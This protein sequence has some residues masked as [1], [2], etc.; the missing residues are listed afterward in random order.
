MTDTLVP[1]RSVRGLLR[2][3]LRG[4]P[5]R[6]L[7]DRDHRAADRR[8]DSGRTGRPAVLAETDR[9]GEL[10][11][12]GGAADD[13]HLVERQVRRGHHRAPLLRRL[14]E[15]RHRRGAGRGARARA[16]R[17]RVR[18][19][20]AAFRHRRQ[21]GRL[22][23]DPRQ[24]GGAARAGHAGRQGCQRS[25]RGAVGRP[26]AQVRQPARARHVAGCR[27]PPHPR[28]P[29]QHLGQDVPSALVRHRSA[30]PA[31]RLRPGPPG[32]PGVQAADP[33][34]RLLGLSATDQLR[35]DAGDRRRGRSHLHGRHGAL[36]G[37]GGRQGL[38]RRRGSRAACA[39]RHDDHPQ[40]AARPARRHGAG[41]QG[42]R[43]LG[44]PRLPDGARRPARPC[45]GGE[46]RRAGRGPDAGVPDLRPGDRRQ[47]EDPRRRSA[48]TGGQPGHRRHR[49]P[50][51]ADRCVRLR[52]HRPAGRVRAARRGHRDQSERGPV[53]PERRL[54]HLRDPDRHPG[55]D[56]SRLRRRRVRPGRRPHRH[57][58]EEHHPVTAST[59][60]PGKAKYLLADGIADAT[61]KASAELLDANPLYPGL[62]L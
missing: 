19:R 8:R 31:D 14:P 17:R 10:R 9:F 12:A 61:K 20:P 15:R 2:H 25:D 39:S 22:L 36:R 37:P 59:G 60:Q 45:D 34:R 43:R 62:E 7:G 5:G 11:L 3:R 28:L 56:V 54:V 53:R 24:P 48:E 18:L 47:R 33:D 50:P 55:A 29:A 1:D 26:S 30:D 41:D 42:V 52:H 40:V 13:G 4:L 32:R 23:G 51:G 35:Q 44:R 6:A 38:H 57:R 21:P 27:R 58:A 16:V 49:Q 46:G